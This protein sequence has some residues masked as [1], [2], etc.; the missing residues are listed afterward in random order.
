MDGDQH[1]KSDIKKL[2]YKPEFLGENRQ[3]SFLNHW[4]KCCLDQDFAVTEN[5]QFMFQWS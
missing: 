2:E 3:C 4:D 5:I 1:M